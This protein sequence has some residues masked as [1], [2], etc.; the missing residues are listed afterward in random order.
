MLTEEQ[1]DNW[2]NYKPPTVE[3]LPKYKA[4]GAERNACLAMVAEIQSEMSQE[5]CYPLIAKTLRTFMEVIDANAPDSADKS[6][7][8]RC[9]ANAR[10]ACNEFVAGRASGVE[11]ARCIPIAIDNIMLARWQANRSIACGGK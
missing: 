4:I 1:L 8:F 7:A 11:R 9:V 6:A 2:F 5:D 10:M 3:N